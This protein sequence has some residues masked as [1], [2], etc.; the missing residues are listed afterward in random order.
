MDHVV[1]EQHSKFIEGLVAAYIM[2]TAVLFHFTDSL[3]YHVYSPM[4]QIMS[5]TSWSYWLAVISLG[6]ISALYLNGRNKFISAPVR[7]VTC[8]L[9]MFGL[10]TIA[11]CFSSAG[12]YWPV[13][14]MGFLSFLLVT[15]LVESVK[16]TFCRNRW[17]M[18]WK[19]S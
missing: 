15:P 7:M 10:G 17:E 16:N 12:V 14:T 13:A 4:L 19:E 6:H 3:S 2:V 9:H 8:G 1:T 11:Y 5:S 18:K